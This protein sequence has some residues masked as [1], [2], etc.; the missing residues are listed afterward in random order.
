MWKNCQVYVIRSDQD[1]WMI[2]E[3][4]TADLIRRSIRYGHQNV[5]INETVYKICWGHYRSTLDIRIVYCINPGDDSVAY[6]IAHTDDLPDV[7]TV[8]YSEHVDPMKGLLREIEAVRVERNVTR[9]L[10]GARLERETELAGWRFRKCLQDLD[11]G[12]RYR[13]RR[14]RHERAREELLQ[15]DVDQTAALG[16]K[17]QV[18]FEEDDGSRTGMRWIVSEKILKCFRTEIDATLR[19]HEGQFC[20]TAGEQS[21]DV[22]WKYGHEGLQ[23]TQQNTVTG[24]SRNVWILVV[25]AAYDWLEYWLSL[26]IP[27]HQPILHETLM[28]QA[29]ESLHALCRDPTKPRQGRPGYRFVPCHDRP[30]AETRIVPCHDRPNAETRIEWLRM[31]ERY[32]E[33]VRLGQGQM[34]RICVGFHGAQQHHDNVLHEGLK[35]SHGP[36]VYGCGPDEAYVTTDLV[37]Y[38]HYPGFLTKIRENLYKLLGVMWI[39]YDHKSPARS[40]KTDAR[41]DSDGVHVVKTAACSVFCEMLVEQIEG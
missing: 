20:Y 14:D 17:F 35:R 12:S 6:A 8:H 23:M 19:G 40:C 1:E 21:Y 28:H 26:Q 39:E 15:P 29:T 31:Q 16:P 25:E 24:N 11:L 33:A 10:D 9:L 27:Q 34:P 4:E 18:S 22:S 32:K 7:P 13:K 3:N 41:E 38:G 5:T 36:G 30:N 37:Y 2:L